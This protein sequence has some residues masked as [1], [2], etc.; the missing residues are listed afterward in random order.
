MI[1]SCTSCSAR[2]K[3]DESKIKGRGAKITCPK[4]KHVFVVYKEAAEASAPPPDVDHLDFQTVGITWRVRTQGGLDHELHELAVLRDYLDDGRID[5][6][7]S[8]S[9]DDGSTWLPINAITDLDAYFLDVWERA[10]RG[11]LAP[12]RK[13]KADFDEED[14]ADAP[15]TIVN[16]GAS[17]ADAIR[18][19]VKEA[20]TPAPAQPRKGMYSP[21][22][23]LAP[24]PP[25]SPP[26]PPPDP[27]RLLGSASERDLPRTAAPPP[28]ESRASTVGIIL[29]GAGVGLALLILALIG[30]GFVEIP[31]INTPRDQVEEPSPTPAAPADPVDVPEPTPPE[32]EG[33]TTTEPADDAEGSSPD[34]TEPTRGPGDA[35]GA[36]TA[37]GGGQ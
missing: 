12:K 18:Q 9:Y 27:P 33:A 7:D 16:R 6:R 32:G 11:E 25:D 31:G 21:Q 13:L 4:C 17:L 36:A 35:S 19:A 24:A 22:Q 23:V 28:P 5:I 30:L 10:S 3:V 14:E 15:T 8:L 1:V 29:V 2:Y 20:A 37:G 34:A 26:T